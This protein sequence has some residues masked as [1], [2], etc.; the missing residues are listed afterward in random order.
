[1]CRVAP[2]RLQFHVGDAMAA[3]ALSGA[4]KDFV[5]LRFQRFAEI[6]F[7]VRKP[8]EFGARNI[9]ADRQDYELGVGSL[10]QSGGSIDGSVRA[11]RAVG[12]DHDARHAPCPGI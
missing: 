12:R 7:D 11:W 6:A 4:C 10:R 1:M 8:P 3:D 2:S 5:D 9:S